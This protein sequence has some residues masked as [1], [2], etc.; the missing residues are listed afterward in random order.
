MI[1]VRSLTIALLLLAA[2]AARAHQ[3]VEVDILRAPETAAP[4]S[5]IHVEGAVTNCGDPVRG[6]VTTWTLVSVSGDRTHLMR[7]VVVQVHPGRTLTGV[8]RLMIPRGVRPGTYD[9][10]LTGQAPLGFTDSDAVRIEITRGRGAG[11]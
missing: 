7:R 8:S 2:P 5:L 9:L 6:F 4:G 11:R 10:I 3:C 1:Q